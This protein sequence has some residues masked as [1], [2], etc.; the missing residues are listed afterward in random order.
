MLLHYYLPY[1]VIALCVI[2]LY[3]Y[4]VLALFFVNVLLENYVLV[5]K[6]V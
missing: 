6:S 3:C 2:M 4:I 1:Y 5:F